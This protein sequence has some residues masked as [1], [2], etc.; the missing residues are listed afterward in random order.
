LD[1]ESALDRLT[2]ETLETDAALQRV[3][4]QFPQTPVPASQV[5]VTPDTA[6][7]DSLLSDPTLQPKGVVAPKPTLGERVTTKAGELYDLGVAKAEEA[8]S[9]LPKRVVQG[10]TTQVMQAVGL[11]D[12]PQYSYQQYTIAPPAIDMGATTSIGEELF[13]GQPEQFYRAYSGEMQS[14][15]WGASAAFY[16]LY[17]EYMQRLMTA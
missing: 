2:A 10:A 15:P 11:E 4:E 16:N 9:D 17:P 3:A 13:T 12:E 14:K 5:T 7:I 6:G 1:T 8:I